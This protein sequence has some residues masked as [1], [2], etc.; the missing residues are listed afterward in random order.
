MRRGFYDFY[1]S[2]ESPLAAEVLGRIRSLY[3]IE[4]EIRVYPAEHRRRVDSGVLSL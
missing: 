2:N 4:A 1:V 3:A